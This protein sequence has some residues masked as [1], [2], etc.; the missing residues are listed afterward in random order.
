MTWRDRAACRAP[1]VD[2]EW[3]F[4]P[5]GRTGSDGENVHTRRAKDVCARCGVKDPCLAEA[6][7]HPQ[8]GVWGGL[9]ETERAALVR[10]RGGR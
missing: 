8:R 2:A 6:L 9:T 1:D 5:V 4:P 10:E 7:E 3:F